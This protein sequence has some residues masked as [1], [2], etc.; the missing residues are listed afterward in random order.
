MLG[1]SKP[2]IISFIT[3]FDFNTQAGGRYDV[4]S[5]VTPDGTVTATIPDYTG[6]VSALS[7]TSTQAN[8]LYQSGPTDGVVGPTILFAP[9]A[10]TDALVR[11]Q[12]SMIFVGLRSYTPATYPTGIPDSFIVAVAALGYTGGGVLG[13]NLAGATNAMDG[14]KSPAA[15]TPID[16][17]N[18]VPNSDLGHAFCG[19]QQINSAT[20]TDIKAT[21]MD[22]RITLPAP[23][24]A[25]PFQPLQMYTDGLTANFPTATQTGACVLLATRST[26]VGA[27]TL[28]TSPS[29]TTDI[30][31]AGVAVPSQTLVQSP[32]T[33]TGAWTPTKSMY[34]YSVT[35]LTTAPSRTSILKTYTIAGDKTEFIFYYD[36]NPVTL[37]TGQLQVQAMIN[38]VTYPAV[39]VTTDSTF[40]QV[41]FHVPLGTTSI[42]TNLTLFGLTTGADAVVQEGLYQY[43]NV[44]SNAQ[45]T[46]S[47]PNVTGFTTGVDPTSNPPACLL[48]DTSLNLVYSNGVCAC[49]PYYFVDASN[50]GTCQPC[51]DPLC[52]TCVTTSTTCTMCSGNSTLVTSSTS[53]TSCVCID[54]FYRSGGVCVPCPIGCATCTSPTACLT[55]A[56]SV[57]ATTGLATRGNT[58]VNC[59]CLAG[60]YDVNTTAVCAPCSPLCA[61]CFN[62][63]TNCTSCNTAANFIAQQNSCVCAPQFY[64]LGTTCVACSP[65]CQT[66]AV[67]SIYCLTCPSMRVLAGTSNPAYKTC[68]CNTTAGYVEVDNV[69]VDATCSDIDPYCRQCSLDLTGLRLRTCYNCIGNR[70]YVQNQCVCAP[71]FYENANKVC[72]P[73]G[74]GCQQCT[75]ATVC[76]SCASA[77]TPNGDGTCSCRTGS[78]LITFANGLYCQPC[79]INCAS[80]SVVS[81]NCTSCKNG[82]VLQNGV[83]I[84]PVGTYPSADGLQCIPCAAKCDSCVNGTGCDRCSTGYLWDNVLKQCTLNCL[85]GSFNS[86]SQCTPCPAGCS[87]CFTELI[88]SSCLTGFNMYAGS[89]RSTCP[90]GTYASGGNCYPCSA[91]CK[92]CS[93]ATQCNSCNGQYVLLANQ[94]V[95]DCLNGTFYAAGSCRACDPGCLTC[96]GYS[97]YCTSCPSPLLL[98]NNTCYTTCPVATV[99][100][101]CTSNCPAGSFLS[102][103]TCTSCDATCATCW[104]TATNCT[105]CAS[106]L[107]SNGAC[108]QSCPDGTF[109]SNGFCSSCDISCTTCSGTP[110]TCIQCAPGFIRTGSFCIKSCPAGYFFDSVSSSCVACA[111]N[112]AR[113]ISATSCTVCI[114]PL[115]TPVN[116]VCQRI[117][118]AGATPNGNTCVCNF[119][120][121]HQSACVSAC[122]DGF[123]A[124]TD[125]VCAM[126][127]APC[128]T[129]SGSATNCVSCITGYTYNSVTNTC[130]QSSTCPYG[131]FTNANG[132]CQRYC[133]TSYFY[134]SGCIFSCPTGYAP[135]DYGGCV[136][137]VSPTFCQVPT[138]LQG[139]TCVQSC[140]AGY[141]PNSVTRTCDRCFANCQQCLSATACVTC[142]TGFLLNSD[143]TACV[144]S[145]ACQTGQVQYKSVCYNTC[146]LGTYQS[147]Q[148]CIRSCPAN[149]YFYQEYCYPTCPAETSFSNPDACVTQCPAGLAGCG[150]IIR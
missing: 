11:V 88:C 87:S 147:G 17:W 27:E 73:C 52:V 76:L 112:C 80:C 135:N 107:S 21:E 136:Q 99:N 67:S 32:N 1:C 2:I 16:L 43:S 98:F 28:V 104:G 46:T 114:D 84:C 14:L 33:G 81:S 121:L 65:I 41:I 97:T 144:Q 129:C 30:T 72:T 113:C 71:G 124:T 131:S 103:T 111:A 108:I 95:S 86:G 42:A 142:A 118:P 82:M 48:C 62:T 37:A 106:G 50:N 74:A 34:T 91:A 13:A 96:T 139:S 149:T 132:V 125:R 85:Q 130:T 4:S 150:P 119:G 23:G 26:C 19:L 60:F 141:F 24:T 35:G 31:G 89:C 40:G 29:Y 117:C 64:L 63:P 45:C 54:G 47:C 9:T 3:G 90:D 83:C 59:A 128:F 58:T 36:V 133:P 110:F 79:T 8:Y 105:S 143:R 116:G 5:F 78:L 138:F 15:G 44:V 101:V 93:S 68:S 145:S 22:L 20:L 126:C 109:A 51:S 39:P 122:P 6:V 57:N 123:Y 94:C 148:I 70:V 127:T 61:T 66:C 38:G 146:P 115:N 120:V 77:S 12:L 92:T 10:G 75:N 140:L 18:Y 25:S 134:N 53:A 100:G 56:N 102:G 137:S 55:C 49:K 69:C 7:T